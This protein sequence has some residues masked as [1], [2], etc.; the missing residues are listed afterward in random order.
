MMA[1]E[2]IATLVT[3]F[4]GVVAVLIWMNSRISALRKENG[5]LRAHLQE[6]KTA[7]RQPAN[8]DYLVDGEGHRLCIHCYSTSQRRWKLLHDASGWK[9]PVCGAESRLDAAPAS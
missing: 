7:P 8:A 4:S 5:V 2:L 9:C 6:L 1:L 3:I